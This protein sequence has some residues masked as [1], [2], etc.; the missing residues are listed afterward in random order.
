MTRTRGDRSNSSRPLVFS[1]RV[2]I[3]VVNLA[4]A[5]LLIGGA[6]RVFML[7]TDQH[8]KFAALAA[9]MQRRITDL[10]HKRGPILDRN[11]NHLAETVEAY[12]L[13]IRRAKVENLDELL[14]FVAGI[15]GASLE[16][17][18][19]MADC[20]SAYCGL[21]RGQGP[22]VK[23]AIDGIRAYVPED[24][25]NVDPV[26]MARIKAIAGLE[27]DS[28]ARRYYSGRELAG[29]VLGKAGF[30]S[31]E[32]LRD[33]GRVAYRFELEGK[34]GV[35][36]S[37]DS[38]L[39]GKP[40]RVSGLRLRK[41]RISYT[42]EFPDLKATGNSL[43][44]TIDSEIQSITE[45][46]LSKALVRFQSPWA[47]GVVENVQTGEILAMAQV[48]LVNPN[49]V[50]TDLP[51]N[52]A[53]QERFEPGSSLKPLVLAAVLNEGLL[54]LDE[55]MDLHN[56][57][58]RRGGVTI[59]DTHPMAS[60]PLRDILKYSSNIGFSQLG[61]DFLGRELLVQYF[62]DFGL[63]RT[64]GVDPKLEAP[65][66][67]RPVQE[68]GPVD[69]MNMSFGQGLMVTPIQLLNS[70]A[71]IGNGGRLMRPYY[72]SHAI[73]PDGTELFRNRPVVL[74]QSI[75]AET[76]A[77]MLELMERVTDDDGT[78]SLAN[79]PGFRV[80]GKTG[81]AQQSLPIHDPRNPSQILTW[82]YGPSWRASF[83]GMVPAE[84]PKIAILI[85]VADPQIGETGGM[86]A[87][88]I[89]AEVAP[90]VLRH[91]GIEPNDT[92]LAKAQPG[93]QK[94]RPPEGVKPR[95]PRTKPSVL[96]GQTLVPDFKSLTVAQ[97]LKVAADNRLELKVLGSGRAV[98]QRPAP[99]T[100]VSEFTEIQVSFTA[101]PEKREV[102][103]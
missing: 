79:I 38:L 90:R 73:A 60:A 43:V 83:V 5:A 31:A 80:A 32:K 12:A 101:D 28:E 44:L 37:F 23:A 68:L 19:K 27:I 67:I 87:A 11:G 40:S 17:L 58:Y 70:I 21:L 65:G 7:Q 48:P 1:P 84:A 100:L 4:L 95:P 97:A 47:I 82:E 88:P 69:V 64:L 36:K 9:N 46:A 57:A 18:K 98:S 66:H 20:S 49:V 52:R 102:V 62:E 14:G 6:I 30:P 92:L 53:I 8:E 72:V 56:G 50:D 86:V 39:S 103:Q 91:M 16:H 54:G 35:E 75:S 15:T 45:K 29:A 78:G 25:D 41:G 33:E 22:T 77:T 10:Y 96:E 93:N 2:R 94:L 63:G 81:T 26:K 34:L 71:A 89:F 13:G 61:V 3:V 85:M 24:K 42:E 74:K 55:I 99:E 51:I 59:N 76:A